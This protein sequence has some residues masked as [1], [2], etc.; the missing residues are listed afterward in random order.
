MENSVLLQR[1]E[2]DDGYV[3]STGTSI[4]AV[5]LKFENDR[6]RE[7]VEQL[8]ELDP[9]LLLLIEVNQAWDARLEPLKSRYAH[10]V[11]PVLEEGL[12]VA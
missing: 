4:C 7:V 11:G 3:H 1:V 10:R 5:N 12:G 2:V 8:R 9:D 6:A